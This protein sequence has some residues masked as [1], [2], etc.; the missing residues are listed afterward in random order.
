[1]TCVASM[2]APRNV[3]NDNQDEP[4]ESLNCVIDEAST[5]VISWVGCENCGSWYHS[6]CVGLGEKHQAEI[7][8]IEYLCD[9][10][11]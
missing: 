4:Y 10:C 11:N 1:M 2:Q 7:T 6:I 9:D 5:S 3:E 8:N